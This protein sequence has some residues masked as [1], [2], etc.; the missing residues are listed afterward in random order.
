PGTSFPIKGGTNPTANAGDTAAFNANAAAKA[1]GATP[2]KRP[3]NMAWLPGSNFGTFFF[4]P[5]GDTDAVAG[6]NPF[7]Q[8]RG[9]YG[10]IFRVD[11]GGNVSG[12]EGEI[13]LFLLGDHDHNSFDNLA[14][15]N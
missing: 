3:E 4:D 15:I 9:S 12:G 8:A 6:E 1:A 13:S 7:L 2:F 10:A 14:F 5:T 11:L